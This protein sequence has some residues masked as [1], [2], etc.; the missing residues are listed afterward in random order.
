M[1]LISGLATDNHD[2]VEVEK[3]VSESLL[4]C[5]YDRV[6]LGKSDASNGIPTSQTASDSLH[7]LLKAAGINGPVLLVGHSYGGLIAQL[8]AAQHPENT[9][10]VVL[11]DSLHDENLERAAEVLGD[12]AIAALS[13]ALDA[14]LEGVDVA[15][16]LSQVKDLDL[17]DTP[18]TVLTAGN[19]DLPE[20]FHRDAVDLLA[21]Y[22][23]YSQRELARMSTTGVQF[24][25]EESGHCIQCDRPDVVVDSIRE[26]A[27]EVRFK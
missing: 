10:G 9:F 5:S 16:S 26:M 15:A 13:L 20:F 12:Q 3:Q 27:D 25:A 14:N 23:L 19:S 21:S 2:W 11:V 6:G 18:L 7:L 1:V 4:I 24:V 17:G 8:Y 22:W